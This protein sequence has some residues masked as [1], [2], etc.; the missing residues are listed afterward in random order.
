MINQETLEKKVDKI[1][2]QNAF[3]Q[4]LSGYG[5]QIAHLEPAKQTQTTQRWKIHLKTQVQSCLIH[6]KIE[7]S[8]RENDIHSKLN[9]LRTDYHQLLTVSGEL[10]TALMASINQ[11][12]VRPQI[13][14]TIAD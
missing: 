8:R 4:I 7:F 5:L 2:K 11:E 9:H 14:F 12:K 3:S 6:T 1:L 13:T 10:V